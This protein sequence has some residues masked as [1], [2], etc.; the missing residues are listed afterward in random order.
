VRVAI[1][2]HLPE[3]SLEQGMSLPCIHLMQIL[4]KICID[5]SEL[6]KVET[7]VHDA[8]KNKKD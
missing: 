2:K 6:I 3:K 8:N 1:F 4:K 5:L 7:L